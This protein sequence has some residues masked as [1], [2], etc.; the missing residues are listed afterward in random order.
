[1][2][3]VLLAGIVALSAAACAHPAR[4]NLLV[5]GSFEE[6]VTS[7]YTVIPAGS[8]D[9]TGWVILSGSV[10]VVGPGSWP[11]YEGDQTLDLDG[12]QPGAIEQ[13]FATIVGGSYSISFAYSNNPYGGQNPAWANVSLS[14]LGLA[15]L[16]DVDIT[17]G[18]STVGDMD[19]FLFSFAFIANSNLTTLRFASLNGGSSGGIVLDA[20]SVTSRN[21]AVPEPSSLALLGIGSVGMLIAARR[22]RRLTVG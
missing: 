16:L 9:L 15:D 1:M 21:S 10:D 7:V 3:R 6:P 13:S 14:G 2:R 19:Y 5:N 11:A 20:V 12:D 8:S 17:H 18:D 22:R 4:A